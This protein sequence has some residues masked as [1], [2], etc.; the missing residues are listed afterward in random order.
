MDPFTARQQA[1]AHRRLVEANAAQER[2]RQAILTQRRLTHDA[3]HPL[4]PTQRSGY[5]Q[6]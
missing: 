6:K 1:E 3:D 4:I 2:R 5:P